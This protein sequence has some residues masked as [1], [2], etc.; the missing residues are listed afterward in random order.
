M[1]I[2][3]QPTIQTGRGGDGELKKMDDLKL[4]TLKNETIRLRKMQ[5]V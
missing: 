4:G 2:R 3:C 5:R 1:K